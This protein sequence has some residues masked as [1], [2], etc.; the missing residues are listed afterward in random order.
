[1]YGCDSVL[2]YHNVVKS[3]VFVKT[4]GLSTNRDDHIALASSIGATLGSVH[5]ATKDGID[6]GL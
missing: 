6:L 5:F 4:V 2:F 3:C 1:M